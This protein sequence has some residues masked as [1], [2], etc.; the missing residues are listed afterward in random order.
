MARVRRRAAVVGGGIGGLAAVAALCSVGWD[1]SVL[2]RAP[3]LRQAE[4]GIGLRPIAIHAL[5]SINPN[6]ARA[7]RC[8]LAQLGHRRVRQALPDRL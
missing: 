3:E 7:L 1:V 8:D 6:L 4:I 2:E 5:K